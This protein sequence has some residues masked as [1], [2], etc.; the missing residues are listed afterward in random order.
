MKKKMKKTK[1]M[2]EKMKKKMLEEEIN[3]FIDKL[4]FVTSL[5][6]VNCLAMFHLLHIMISIT[7]T[8]ITMKNNM[9]NDDKDL[10]IFNAI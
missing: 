6:C 4:L 5:P 10:S 9:I 3:L 2:K 7:M 8:M 1:E